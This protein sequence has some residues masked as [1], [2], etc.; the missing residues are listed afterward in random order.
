MLT[1]AGRWPEAERE[2]GTA[3]E[4]YDRSYRALRPAALVRLADVRVRQGRFEEAGRLLAD[5]EHDSHAIRPQVELH[6]A[7]GES[8][9]AV[10]RIERFLRRHPAG[11]PRVPVLMLLVRARRAAGDPA[12]AAAVASDLERGA[13]ETSHPVFRALAQYARGLVAVAQG[14]PAAT[15]HPESAT[16]EFAR[17]GL[18]FEEGR[19]RL[20]LARGV[21]AEPSIAV[22]EARAAL[23]IFQTLSATREAEAATSL[24]RALGV[25]GHTG[26][27]GAGTLTAREEDVLALLGQGRSNA[28]IA[29]HLFL[30]RRTV[31]HHVSNILAKLGLATRAEATAYFLTRVSGT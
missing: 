23:H 26:P 3:V 20:D 6:L 15:A 12:G 31:E 27:R 5:A 1:A 22:V 25:R 19:A 2:L 18:P 10:A 30:S 17:L 4:L 21:A 13:S 24:L 7:R 8:E 28:G 29:G 9:L 11:E 14:D 16:T